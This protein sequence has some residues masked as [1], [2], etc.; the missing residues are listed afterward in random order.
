MNADHQLRLLPS[1]DAARPAHSSVGLSR[2][3][4]VATKHHQ[5]LRRCMEEARHAM[6]M[7]GD[8]SQSHPAKRRLWH[9]MTDALCR[10]QYRHGCHNTNACDKRDE[11]AAAWENEWRVPSG[12]DQVQMCA[13]EAK[14]GCGGRWAVHTREPAA[15]EPAKLRDPSF[16]PTVTSESTSEMPLPSPPLAA[17]ARA[18]APACIH[19]HS[20]T[21]SRPPSQRSNHGDSRPRPC[22][23]PVTGDG[24]CVR[25]QHGSH[26]PHWRWGGWCRQTQPLERGCAGSTSW[27]G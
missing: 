19:M 4:I 11:A 13:S 18:A 7:H 20:A 5:V 8:G 15:R 12:W 9:P 16:P 23:C 3:L 14:A 17:S 24:A 2:P 10:E 26:S 22:C 1:P 27:S 25:N 6:A 21:C